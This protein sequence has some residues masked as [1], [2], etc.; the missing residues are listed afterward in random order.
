MKDKITDFTASGMEM[1]ATEVK[2]HAKRIRVFGT[3]HSD[4]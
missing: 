3:G 2:A 1:S 4:Q